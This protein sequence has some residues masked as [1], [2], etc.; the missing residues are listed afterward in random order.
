MWLNLISG[1]FTAN[2]VRVCGL[3]ECLFNHM[4]LNISMDVYYFWLQGSNG[5]AKRTRERDLGIVLPSDSGM[6]NIWNHRSLCDLCRNA[7]TA[8]KEGFC[9]K[10]AGKGLM[11]DQRK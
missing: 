2:L 4:F 8:N 6:H 1:S 9:C 11:E 7:R 10:A 3:V 5:L